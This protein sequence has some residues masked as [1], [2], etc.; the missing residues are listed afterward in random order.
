MSA[1][2]DLNDSDAVWR[3]MTDEERRDFQ[4]LVKRGNF[5]E[6]L[7]A[8]SAWWEQ[9]VQLVQEVKQ[10]SPT[11]PSYMANCPNLVKVPPLSEL[12]VNAHLHKMSLCLL[13]IHVLIPLVSLSL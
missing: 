11:S 1:G 4:E 5:E 3:N 7:P 2:V 8:W 12:T 6:L 9:E 13:Y 10:D